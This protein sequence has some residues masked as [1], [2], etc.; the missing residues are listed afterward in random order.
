[1]FKI[2]LGNNNSTLDLKF[3]ILESR[4]A[5]KWYTELCKNYEL[6]ETTRFTDWNSNNIVPLINNE[7][8]IINNYSYVITKNCPNVPTQKD[9]N[10][11]HKFFEDLRGEVEIGTN[12]YVMA[13]IQ[14][15]QSLERLNVYIHMGEAQLRTKGKHPTIVVTFKDRPRFLLDDNDCKHFTTLWK[16]GYVYINYCQV[17]KTIL[18]AYKDKDTICEAIRPQTHY[19]AD[20][21]VKFGPGSNFIFDLVKQYNLHRYIRKNNLNYKHYNLGMIP[22]AKCVKFD[23]S[24]LNYNRVVNVQCLA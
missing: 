14:I 21:M 9:F 3:T 19:S 4:I 15:K 22:V 10:Q 8:S 11:L 18:D 6:Y 5:K 24:I 2:T 17:G 23:N 20:F 13:P 7:I 16:S 12:F 1:M